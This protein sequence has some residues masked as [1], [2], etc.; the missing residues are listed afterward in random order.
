MKIFQILFIPLLSVTSAL[1]QPLIF[2]SLADMPTGRGAISSA[3]DGTHF[4]VSN[5]F[6]AK[7]KFTGLIEKYDISKNEWSVLT[8]SLIPKQFPSSI[9]VGKELYVF[10]GDLKDG[11]LNAK[12]EVVDISTGQIQ[13]STD[14]P[15]PA[16]AAGVAEWN[17]IIYA[18]GGKISPDKLIYSNSLYKFDPAEKKW[19]KLSSMPE[20][21]ETKGVIVDGKLYV[22]GGYNGEASNRITMYDI[23][24]DKW[25]KLTKLPF[26]VSAHSVVAYGDKI[27]VVF[28]FTNQS[29]IG[30]YD[31]PA[32]KFVILEQSGMTGRRHAG[33]HIVNDKLYIM[34]GNTSAAMQRCL[35]ST[36]VADLK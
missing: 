17:E 1:A 32:N 28:D 36:Q 21:K 9:I 16:H 35:S 25:T 3:S 29:F 6:S 4:Y 12:M 24:T 8:A 14:N 20:K 19:T 30:Y 13:F 23:Q 27:Y 10:N 2:Q 26:G 34:G 5:G 33:A 18:F 11:T 22:I 31:I 7:E 15:N